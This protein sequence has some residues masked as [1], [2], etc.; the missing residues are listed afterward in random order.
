MPKGRG[1]GS[2]L[3]ERKSKKFSLAQPMLCWLDS[4]CHTRGGF[5]SFNAPDLV[6][7]SVEVPS[8]TYV[9]SWIILIKT[10]PN[11]W[12]RI[13]YPRRVKINDVCQLNGPQSSHINL[14]NQP[15]QALILLWPPPHDL[16]T[17]QRFHLLIPSPW[18][19]GFSTQEF[20]S[21]G[22]LQSNVCSCTI[23]NPR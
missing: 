20:W 5:S 19:G 11:F 4:A 3:W 22:A 13:P 8:Q 18:G 15:S 6:P 17:S 1:G 21:A 12:G 7:V 2:F 23:I 9:G 10:N 16:V 14:Q